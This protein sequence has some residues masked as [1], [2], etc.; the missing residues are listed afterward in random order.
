M[1]YNPPFRL[2]S[3]KLFSTNVVSC[4]NLGSCLGYVENKNASDP[5]LIHGLCTP[6]SFGPVCFYCDKAFG[7]YQN[8]DVCSHCDIIQA[9]LYARLFITFLFVLVNIIVSVGNIEK[10]SKKDADNDLFSIVTKII[11][12]HSQHLMLILRNSLAL[13]DFSFLKNFFNSFD[14]FSFLNIGSF[15]N[16]C[17]MNSLYYNPQKASIYISLYSSIIH[18]VVSLSSNT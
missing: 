2:F 8:E 5:S 6:G 9:L 15:M 16:E 7:K 18:F 11:I 4:P 17:F 1:F 13:P 3:Q 10:F 12:N 14:Y